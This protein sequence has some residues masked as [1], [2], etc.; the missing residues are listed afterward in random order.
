M[1]ATR[2]ARRAPGRYFLGDRLELGRQ[3]PG[4]TWPETEA[5]IVASGVLPAA[6]PA[7]SLGGTRDAARDP[8]PEGK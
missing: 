1:A 5:A 8:P 6:T 7:V 4:L 2:G 3:R